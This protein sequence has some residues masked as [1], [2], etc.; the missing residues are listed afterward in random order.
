[1]IRRCV[2]A[3]SVRL[4]IGHA[5]RLAF[6]KAELRRPFISARKPLDTQV[7]AALTRAVLTYKSFTLGSKDRSAEK[8][9]KKD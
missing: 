3:I 8:S 5:H 2:L 7:F 4:I 1:M 6:F 9:P